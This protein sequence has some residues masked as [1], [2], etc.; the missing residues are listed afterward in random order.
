[1]FLLETIQTDG[2]AQLSYL[3]GDTSTQTAAVI[4]PRTDVDI[5]VELARKKKLSITHIFETHIHADFVSG[6]RSLADRLGSAKIYLS[7]QDANY[8]FQGESVSDGDQFDFGSFTL[9]ARHTPGHTPEHMSFELVLSEH[10]D[11]IAGV[12]TGDS[13]FVGSAGRPDLLGDKQ[14]VELAQA[15]HRTLYDYYLKLADHVM[16]YPGHGAG[17]ACGADIGDR[18]VSTIGFERRT[19]K[20]LQQPD[21][22]A[23]R[24]LVIEQ[25]PPVP[26]HYPYL[27][28]INARGPDILDRLPTIPALPPGEFKKAAGQP[29][30]TVVDTRSMLAFGGGHIPGSINIGDRSDLSVWIGQMIDPDQKLL[31]IA[32]EDADIE[33]ILRLTIRTGH[34]QFAGYLAGSMKAWE[35]AGCPIEELP[36]ISVKELS[37]ILEGNSQHT[38]LDVRSPEEFEAGHIPGAEHYFVADMRNRI[39]GLD[40]DRSYIT[41]CASGYRAS[42]ASSLMKTRGFKHVMNVPGSWEAWTANHLPVASLV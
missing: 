1:M 19:N 16:I 32:D 7:G 24:R 26:S 2:I 42:L 27:K 22:E 11:W 17:S 41:Y 14:T 18:L 31:L 13:L 36:Q 34:S 5:Y 33:E 4:D 15:L 25:A 35:T 8:D 9:I 37:Q 21:F 30:V 3:L 6:S 12:F 39:D 20:F 38:L 29:G 23:F 10:Q 28:K 40:K